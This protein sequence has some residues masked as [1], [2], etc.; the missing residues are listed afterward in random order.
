MTKYTDFVKALAAEKKITYKEAMAQAKGL[1]KK[2]IES[3]KCVIEVAELKEVVVPEVVVPE[4]VAPVIEPLDLA[5]VIHI[6]LDPLTSGVVLK[7]PRKARAK[8][9]CA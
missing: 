4:V 7:K 5:P 8:S 3:P 6:H 9:I 1:Y 2:D